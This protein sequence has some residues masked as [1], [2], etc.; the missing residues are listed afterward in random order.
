[1]ASRTTI[2]KSITHAPARL[3]N[4]ASDTPSS[5]SARMRVCDE[6]VRFKWD[7]FADAS[8]LLMWKRCSHPDTDYRIGIIARARAKAASLTPAPLVF[9]SHSSLQIVGVPVFFFPVFLPREFA[10]CFDVLVTR[11]VHAEDPAV[12]CNH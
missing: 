9:P 4:G 3:Q 12:E 6:N 7:M 11:I 1:M 2:R 10:R 8:P 5:A